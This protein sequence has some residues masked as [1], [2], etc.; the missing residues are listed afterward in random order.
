MAVAGVAESV[1]VL[2]APAM[3]KEAGFALTPLGKP[4]KVT[5]HRTTESAASVDANGKSPTAAGRD[6]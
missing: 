5:A 4:L 3:F 6:F 1:V 2:L